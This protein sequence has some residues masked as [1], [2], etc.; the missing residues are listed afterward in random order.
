MLLIS[1]DKVE[2]RTR[3]NHNVEEEKIEMIGK[4]KKN[5]IKCVI[6]SQHAVKYINNILEASD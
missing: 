5:L 6:N 3:K 1:R 4:R 2:K